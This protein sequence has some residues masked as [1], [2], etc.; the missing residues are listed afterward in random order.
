MFDTYYSAIEL[1]LKVVNTEITKIIHL[2]NN[3]NKKKQWLDGTKIP[4]K[5][6]LF[7]ENSNR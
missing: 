5:N 7:K 2:R 3:K 4:D 6:K 1:A